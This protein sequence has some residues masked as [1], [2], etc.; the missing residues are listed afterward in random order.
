MVSY[1]GFVSTKIWMG[2]GLQC[3]RCGLIMHKK[4]FKRGPSA[5]KKWCSVNQSIAKIDD[6]FISNVPATPAEGVKVRLNQ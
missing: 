3:R 2:D 4:C 5:E 6:F 1:Y